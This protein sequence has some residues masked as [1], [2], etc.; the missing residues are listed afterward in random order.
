MNRFLLAVPVAVGLHSLLLV[1]PF[2]TFKEVQPVLAPVKRI[3]VSLTSKTAT[4]Q[5]TKQPAKVEKKKKEAVKPKPKAEKVKPPFPPPP[6]PKTRPVIKRKVE[7]VK[8]EANQVRS[9]PK[10][11]NPVAA[12]ETGVE[13]TKTEDPAELKEQQG[14]TGASIV[15]KAMPLYQ[16]NPPPDYPYQARRRGFEGTVVI[17]AL[18][19]VSGR[20]A[21]LRLAASSG[22]RSLDKAAIKAVRKWRFTPGSQGGVMKEMWVRVPVSF[23]LK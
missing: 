19:S 22:H 6:E 14:E 15:R 1:M 8:A 9:A 21:D 7:P 5:V 23:R 13:T 12:V 10:N 18:I 2:A 4:R 17:E 16:I 3:S 20:V 11:L